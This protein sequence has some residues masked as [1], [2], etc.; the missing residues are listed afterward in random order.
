MTKIENASTPL[1]VL[2]FVDTAA[3]ETWLSGHYTTA[4]VWIKIAKKNAKKPT[5]TYQQ[6]LDAALCYGWI[7]SQG[8][9]FDSEY[10]LQKFTPR[11]ARSIWSKTNRARVMEL[12]E[13]GRMQTPGFA[14]IEAAKANGRWDTAYDS[15]RTIEIPPD[16]QAALDEHPR[17]K[18]FFETVNSQNRYAIVHR[19]Q[20][21][22]T[23]EIRRQRIEQYIHMLEMGE[24]IYP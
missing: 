15:F 22:R 23:G 8:K 3:W 21:A 1:P 16:F 17:A 11:G 7:D 19:I 12:I 13:Q 5:V 20:I 10:Y 4:G 24:K 18:A 14:A 6:A 9:S 2:L